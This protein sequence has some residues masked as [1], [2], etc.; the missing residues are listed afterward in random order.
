ML[1]RV[2]T[3][4]A[5]TLLACALAAAPAQA[6]AATGAAAL[7]GTVDVVYGPVSGAGYCINRVDSRSVVSPYRT[8]GYVCLLTNGTAI[9][10]NPLSACAYHEPTR[11][12]VG[13]F[14]HPTEALIC[15]YAV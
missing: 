2:L 9:P 14:R 11:V 10:A 8:T 6:T 5:G 1:R 7:G 15:R 12:V 3:L 13:A 4:A